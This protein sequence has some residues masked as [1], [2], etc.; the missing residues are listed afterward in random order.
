MSRARTAERVTGVAPGARRGR[1][2][3]RGLAVLTATALAT[4]TLPVA[5]AL[6]APAA[7]AALTEG[8]EVF[9]GTSSFTVQVN[10]TRTVLG[11][12]GGE[13][14]NW[15]R[16][17]VP[18]IAGFKV[19]GAPTAPS[20]W[21][22]EGFASGSLQT[23][24]FRGGSLAPGSSLPFTFPASV[25][26]PK[27]DRTGDFDVAVSSDGGKT[28]S[29]AAGD[30]TSAVKTLQL[31]EG[32]VKAVAPAGVTDQS[33][34][35]GQTVD[36][37][38]AVRNLA[39]LTQR[40]TPSLSSNGND[41]VTQ[42]APADVTTG[43][44]RTF[45]STVAL[46]GSANRE[47]V[48]SA[49]AQ[50]APS[51]TKTITAPFTVQAPASLVLNAGSF[52]PKAVRPG[53]ARTFTVDAT[54]VN[55]PAL[56]IATAEL[57]VP[58]A[59]ASAGTLSVADGSTRTLS[60]G[61][62]TPAGSDGTYDVTARFAGSDSNGFP[63][64]Q[65]VALD[66][67]L[68]LDSL[69]PQIDPFT[70]TLPTDAD[71]RRQTAVSND[72]DRITVQGTL[73]D[74][75]P[76]TLEL[77][78]QPN[79]GAVIP[80]PVT[81]N[82][83]DFTGSVT[84]GGEGTTFASTATSFTAVATATDAAENAGSAAATPVAI[85]LV[86]PVLS[87]A[88]TMGPTSAST[89]ADRILVTFT[90]KNTVFGGCSPSQWKVD[91][92]LLVRS[93]TY[94]NGEPC[95]SGKAGPDNSRVLMLMQSRDQDLQTNVTYTR[96]TRPV[97]DPA[98]DG[99][100][101]DAA[102]ATVATI[103]GVIPAAPE[104][105]TVQRGDGVGGREDAT[106]DE[107]TYWT[108]RP[109]SDLTVEFAGGRPGYTVRVLDGS[110][111]VLASK[112]VAGSPEV[113]SVPLGSADGTLVRKL[114][115]LNDR[116]LASDLTSFTVVL[117]RIRPALGSVAQTDARTVEVTFNE[118]LATGTNFA[119]DWFASKEN[120]DQDP[121]DPDDDR[122][123]YQVGSVSGNGAARTLTTNRDMQGG[124]V[125][126]QYLLRNPDAVRYEDRAGNTLAD[127]LK[128]AS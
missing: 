117:D 95:Q 47:A 103:G 76:S 54:K 64:A 126:A 22:G 100:G 90:E 34:T 36:Y 49:A 59:T 15:V 75:S 121:N 81:R 51:A 42:A 53:L 16:I 85:D 113:V 10:N 1:G 33:G 12:A 23:Y 5:T 19:A 35:A 44:T 112:P 32:S 62:A 97:A 65:T 91:G 40:V 14:V 67:V 4:V 24:T 72:K 127:A 74:C 78:L 38:F 17:Q 66:D 60:F 82:G 125:G 6:A 30:L 89:Q 13:T 25:A 61:P 56:S 7:T 123:I 29:G 80:V 58:G 118:V 115:L 110:G 111:S 128:R 109:G 18:N 48:F 52:S 114:Q 99:A 27:F 57:V 102:T 46:G 119:E 84:T 50:A 69:G 45:T 98:V 3:R 88:V 79:V 31:V 41:T 63:Y 9:P 73:D 68:T 124:A 116:G 108:N 83:C 107:D 93:V 39:S 20:G 94:S 28:T 87:K 70:V 101:Q 8:K 2:L 86:L 71:G 37:A 55:A 105:L 21:T 96:G 92:E 120:P 104:L 122:E 11:A 106:F 43:E 77:F 26:A